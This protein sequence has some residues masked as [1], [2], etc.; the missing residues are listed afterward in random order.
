MGRGCISSK[1]SSITANKQGKSQNDSED[2]VSYLSVIQFH[3]L[4]RS[5]NDLVKKINDLWIDKD[6]KILMHIH[7]S[8][9][10]IF[11]NK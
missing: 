1:S 3:A 11:L 5:E 8:L 4:S 6:Q 10:L 9:I 2:M 7:K